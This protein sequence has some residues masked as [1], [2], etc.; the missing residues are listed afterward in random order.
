MLS[1]SDRH[2][3][4]A[5]VSVARLTDLAEAEQLQRALLDRTV[6]RCRLEGATWAD[7]GAAL[8]ITRQAAGARFRYLDDLAGDVELRVVTQPDGGR[9]ACFWSVS[10]GAALFEVDESSDMGYAH[11]LDLLRAA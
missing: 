5:A 2:E 9:R 1:R 7:V 4:A 8:S 11:L 6:L 3:A 10:L